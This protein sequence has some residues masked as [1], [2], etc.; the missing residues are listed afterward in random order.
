MSNEEDIVERL[1]R[2]AAR[3]RDRYPEELVDPAT[4]VGG[5]IRD[6][7]AAADEIQRMRDALRDLSRQAL[8]AMLG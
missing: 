5:L 8:R 6:Y 1:R 4:L 7:E 2:R 3:A